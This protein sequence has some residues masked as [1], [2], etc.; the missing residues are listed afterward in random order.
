VVDKRVKHAKQQLTV[1]SEN[2]KHANHL[3][4]Q[5]ESINHKKNGNSTKKL[6][7]GIKALRII[8]PNNVLK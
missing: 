7:K 4:T 1:S 2:L 5:P 8:V 6:F 3:K